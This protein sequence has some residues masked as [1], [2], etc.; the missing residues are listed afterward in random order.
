MAADPRT[1]A[2]HPEAVGLFAALVEATARREHFR[3]ERCLRRLR[4]LGWAVS[5]RRPRDGKGGRRAH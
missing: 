1:L 5:R 2:D 4:D 3:V